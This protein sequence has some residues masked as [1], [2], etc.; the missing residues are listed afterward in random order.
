MIYSQHFFEHFYYPSPM[1]DV[2]LECKRCLKKGAIFSISVPDA[3]IF[4]NAY[5]NREEEQTVRNM[6]VY[7]P[8]FHYNSSI[9]YINYIAYM[10]GIHKYMF[11]TENLPK[12]LEKAGFVNIHERPFDKNLDWRGQSIYMQCS[13]P[14]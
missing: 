13:T 9:D 8:G 5:L 2:L 1:M 6:G 12:I 14:T 7:G 3:T 4:T 10:G 11:D